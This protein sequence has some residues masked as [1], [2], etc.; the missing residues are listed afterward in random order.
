MIDR[1]INAEPG[2]KAWSCLVQQHAQA[3]HAAQ[4]AF[5]RMS[6]QECLAR[7]VDNIGD[8]KGRWSFAQLDRRGKGVLQADAGRVDEQVGITQSGAARIPRNDRELRQ[9][10]EQ[11]L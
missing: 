11:P 1:G 3:A 4:A 7:R 9:V 2:A 8:H 5:C 10:G 6:Q